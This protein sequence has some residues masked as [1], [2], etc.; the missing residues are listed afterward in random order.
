MDSH[1]RL[2]A[3]LS[4]L[5]RGMKELHGQVVED[6]RV[7]CEPAGAVVLSRLDALGPVRLTTLAAELGLD[8]SSV[9]RQ[10]AALERVGLLSKERDDRDLRAQRLVLTAAGR[11]AVNG[12]RTA[13]A[14]RLAQL[15]PG[16]SPAE[17]DDLA[18]R[19]ARLNT[20]IKEHRALSGDRQETA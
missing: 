1:A 2:A 13:F 11:S 9:S 15:T 6:A 16:I 7:P 8:P 19:L 18:D 17:V 5:V 14:Q 20:E 12:L 4:L 3:E 10:V